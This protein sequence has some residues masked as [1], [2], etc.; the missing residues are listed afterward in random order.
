MLIM[1]T[2]DATLSPRFAAAALVAK[3]LAGLTS[4]V[5]APV[6]LCT[7]S[8]A[9]RLRTHNDRNIVLGNCIKAKRGRTYALSSF[10]WLVIALELALNCKQVAE[11]ATG[12]VANEFCG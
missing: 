5:L 4:S 7:G 10:N 9:G 2:L 3:Q 12:T 1:L 11:S 6:L 8:T